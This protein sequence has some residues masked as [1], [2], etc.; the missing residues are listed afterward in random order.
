MSTIRTII[1]G[2]GNSILT[3]DA[4]GPAVARLM[5]QRLGDANV[6][7][8]EASVGGIELVELLAGYD[9]AIIIDAIRTEGGRAGD[10]YLLDLEGS[11]P[12]R[13]TGMTHE[14]GLLEGLEFGRK[15]GRASCR[16]RV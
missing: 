13:R 7:L 16:E 4:V 3:D 5:H 1:I 12:S 2:L 14:V 10:C 11:R 15:I 6:D 8:R 9:K